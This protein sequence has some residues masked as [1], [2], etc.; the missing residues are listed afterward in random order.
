MFSSGSGISPSLV[1][2]VKWSSLISQFTKIL[3]VVWSANG[4]GGYS[5]YFQGY[6]QFLKRQYTNVFVQVIV[7]SIWTNAARC[8]L[9]KKILH[10]LDEEVFLG[11][12]SGRGL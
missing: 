5:Y 1:S 2:V 10:L 8:A 11:E 6:F 9:Y 3:L 4:D 7:S 12:R